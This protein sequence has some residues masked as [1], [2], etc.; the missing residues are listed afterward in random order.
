DSL[1][2]RAGRRTHIVR[3]ISRG[4]GI[5][6]IHEKTNGRSLR[7]NLAKESQPLR[8]SLTKGGR[9][10]GEIA[11]GTVEAAN[12]PFSDRIATGGEKNRNRGGRRLGRQRCLDAAGGDNGGYMTLDQVGYQ[13]RQPV[14]LTVR[15]AILD[16]D[17]PALHQASFAQ[18]LTK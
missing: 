6:G 12:E 2:D 10:A 4:D 17:I 1:P 18:A 15:V 13:G 3:L 14:E 11:S 8:R 9:Y 5:I 7:Q 16:R